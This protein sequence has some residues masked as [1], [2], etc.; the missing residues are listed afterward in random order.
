VNFE[1]RKSNMFHLNSEDYKADLLDA[2]GELLF[3]SDFEWVLKTVD[4]F[5]IIHQNFLKQLLMY[6]GEKLIPISI[7]KFSIKA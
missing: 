3:Y 2:G 4:G 5:A 1:D 6:R 7:S